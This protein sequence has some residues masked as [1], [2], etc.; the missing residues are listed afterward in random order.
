M[1]SFNIQLV[2]MTSR[3]MSGLLVDHGDIIET[4]WRHG[5]YNT[6]YEGALHLCLT[7]DLVCEI[8]ALMEE[9][10]TFLPIIYILLQRKADKRRRRM[11]VEREERVKTKSWGG[12]FL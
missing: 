6:E 7:W 11:M 3:T 2:K 8:A 1:T 5:G 12:L 9:T 4:V 10:H